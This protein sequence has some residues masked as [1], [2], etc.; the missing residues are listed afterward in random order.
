M[1]RPDISSKWVAVCP[2]SI[3]VR[4]FRENGMPNFLVTN[5]FIRNQAWT[6]DTTSA[7]TLQHEQLHFDIA[8]IYARKIRKAVDSLR[9]KNVKTVVSYP[10]EITRLLD[11]RDETDRLYD[12]D[13]SQ[14]FM[15]TNNWN[16]S[17]KFG[18]N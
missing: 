2:A 1:G 18:K 5:S 12:T 17:R 7:G 15:V 3:Y 9:R 10:T 6:K 16:G 14:E 4:G 11:M 13:T 8:E